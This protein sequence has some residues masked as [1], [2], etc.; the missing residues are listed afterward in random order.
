MPT[1]VAFILTGKDFMQESTLINPTTRAGGE[2]SD[3]TIMKDGSNSVVGLYDLSD[4]G[5]FI[6]KIP[7]LADVFLHGPHK[8]RLEEEVAEMVA[9]ILW[10]ENQRPKGRWLVP[11]GIS[12]R[13]R[14]QLVIQSIIA[15]VLF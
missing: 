13:T 15:V 3:S 10:V 12:G 1:H 11:F 5:A 9:P 6:V 2:W 8:I 14:Q 7:T 4:N